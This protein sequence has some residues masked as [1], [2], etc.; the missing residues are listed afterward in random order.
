[1]AD[2]TPDEPD[3]APSPAPA[4]SAREV[5]A[6]APSW[7]GPPPAVGDVIADR[8]RIESAVGEGGIGL[9]FLAEH[10]FLRKRHALKV[11]RPQWSS[12]PDVVTRFEREAVAAGKVDSPHVVA[13]TDF[14]RLPDGTFFLVMEWVDGRTLRSVLAHERIDPARAVKIAAGVAKGLAAAHAMGVVHRDVKPENVMLVERDG[15]PDFVKVL[16]FGI[17]KVDAEAATPPIG[18]VT[19]AGVAIGTP[20][21]MSP[22][23]A[24]GHAVDARS[25]LYSLGILLYE[26]LTGECPYKGEPR[27]VL[28]QHVAA[29]VPVL[30]ESAALSLGSAVPAVLARL[31]AKSPDDRFASATDALRALEGRPSRDELAAPSSRAEPEA[32][33]PLPVVLARTSPRGALR[34]ADHVVTSVLR[35]PRAILRPGAARTVAVGLLAV[36]AVFWLWVL[37]AAA[38]VRPPAVEER[39]APTAPVRPTPEPPASA[40][41]EPPRVKKPGPVPTSPRSS[42]K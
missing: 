12:I 5:R 29:P 31:L 33:S 1:M 26:M 9:V 4:G 2:V 41:P 7:P 20:D 11:L 34:F 8:Y 10:V 14:G 21:Y 23:Q 17:A 32:P 16:D 22:E 35:D 40:K 30:P 6:T 36:S 42:V 13:A 39:A 19:L 24:R 15:D 18:S 38:L 28:E 37:A 27:A 3:A 25:D